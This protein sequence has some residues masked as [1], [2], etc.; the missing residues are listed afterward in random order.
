M[1]NGNTCHQF[2]RKLENT[3]IIPAASCIA[4]DKALGGKWGGGNADPLKRKL[5]E[6]ES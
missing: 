5:S 1:A 4:I 3:V 2:D 6:E